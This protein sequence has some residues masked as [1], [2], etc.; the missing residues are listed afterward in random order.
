MVCVK[1]HGI[2]YGSPLRVER[3]IRRHYDRVSVAVGRTCAVRTRVPTPEAV[4]HADKRIE[5]ECLWPALLVR[6]GGH[7]SLAPVG[8]KAV[9]YLATGK[10]AGGDELS[11]IITWFKNERNG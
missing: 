6:L 8:V 3:Q 10:R 5:H 9:G 11:P 1:G 4:A 2:G 7:G